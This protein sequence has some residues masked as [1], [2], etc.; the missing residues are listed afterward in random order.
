MAHKQD[1]LITM[2]AM[3]GGIVS[4]GLLFLFQ[5]NL[6]KIEMARR[7]LIMVLISSYYVA[8]VKIAMDLAERTVPK[9]QRFIHTYPTLTRRILA[10]VGIVILIPLLLTFLSWQEVVGAVLV[11]VLTLLINMAFRGDNKSSKK[12]KNKNMRKKKGN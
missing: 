9:I 3:L 11:A 6:D 7:A 4:L 8:G 2:L 1:H 12:R 10:I 5:E